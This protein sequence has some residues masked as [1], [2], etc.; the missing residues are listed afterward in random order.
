MTVAIMSAMQEENSH[1]VQEMKISELEN[2]GSRTYYSG[3]IAGK[4]VVVVFSHWGKV[5]AS[6][7]AT[8]LITKFDVDE[9]VFVGTA[10][11]IDEKLSVGDIV[12]GENLYQHDMD[13]RPIIEQY[14]IPLLGRSD[15]A[16]TPVIHDKLFDA[17]NAFV[18]EDIKKLAVFN[19]GAGESIGTP[20]VVKADIASGDQFVSES[21]QA[22][23][24]RQNLPAVGCVE[25]E[26][27]A[28]AQVCE[29]FDVPFGI[30]RTISDGANETSEIDFQKF[31]NELAPEYALGIVKRYLGQ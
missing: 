20:N 5:A 23:R 6:I 2:Y 26:G 18:S 31:L 24:V 29:S 16:T 21:A 19:S 27:A 9:I 30:V 13:A 25:M 11:A 10:G 14:E 22:Q 15:I 3:T 17:A 12:V 1:I 8:C 7:T 4:E 28:V